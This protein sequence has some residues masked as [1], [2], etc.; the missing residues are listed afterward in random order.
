MRK[1]ILL[2]SVLAAVAIAM[3]LGSSAASAATGFCVN[4]QVNNA[5]KCWGAGR[6]LSY[7]QA[8]GSTTGVC[9]GADSTQGTCAPTLQLATVNVPTGEHFPWVIG[10]ASA[11]TVAVGAS[12]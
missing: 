8:Y 9:V 3:S 1:L 12:D 11:F 5:N 2:P 7:A 4:Q 6:V 10:T